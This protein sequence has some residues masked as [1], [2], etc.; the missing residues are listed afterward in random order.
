[1][2]LRA[3]T[4]Y[5][6]SHS[7][8]SGWLRSGGHNK[9]LE[10]YMDRM[11]RCPK[12]GF[13]FPYQTVLLLIVRKNGAEGKDR[14]KDDLKT[15]L[16][17]KARGKVAFSQQAELHGRNEGN[18]NSD[19]IFPQGAPTGEGT[20]G[21]ADLTK[22]VPNLHVQKTNK[23]Q[24]RATK[25][26][27]MTFLTPPSVQVASITKTRQEAGTNMV[28]SDHILRAKVGTTAT[29][30]SIAYSGDVCDTSHGH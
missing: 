10:C 28:A 19:V 8:S 17:P 2:S 21:T 11:L 22:G 12:Q 18:L 24:N 25:Y 4:L 9:S 14:D 16:C 26:H 27:S 3:P 30:S 1:M 5:R 20:E 13:R 7:S 6:S 15:L 23:E 29:R